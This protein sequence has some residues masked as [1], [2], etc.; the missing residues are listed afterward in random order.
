M[1]L[2]NYEFKLKL[3]E[4]KHHRSRKKGQRKSKADKCHLSLTL[5]KHK[6]RKTKENESTI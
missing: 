4:L 3:N 1:N 5:I 2:V 6:P